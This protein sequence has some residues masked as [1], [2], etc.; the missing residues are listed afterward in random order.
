MDSENSTEYQAS[1]FLLE[2]QRNFS[3]KTPR[4]S[5]D[6]VRIC[7]A[8]RYCPPKGYKFASLHGILNLPSKT[9]LT[10][11]VGNIDCN[12]GVTPLI[13]EGLRLEAENLKD[14]E[15][16]SSLIIDEM[17]IKSQLQYDKKLDN[18]FGSNDVKIHVARITDTS[19]E[20]SSTNETVDETSPEKKRKKE[21]ELANNLLCFLLVGL[22]TQYRLPVAFF[23]SRQLCGKDLFVLTKHVLAE[24]EAIGFKIVRIVTDNHKVNANVM[25]SVPITVS[26]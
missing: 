20:C 11:F 1:S 14:E 3:K 17:Y 15:K 23:F 10:R 16:F 8:W 21:P 2:Q 4:W 12:T 6:C 26:Q 24:V 5:A 7:L 19:K 22:S 18:F 13:K 9:T 25:G